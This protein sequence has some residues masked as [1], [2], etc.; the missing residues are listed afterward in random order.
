MPGAC[1]CASAV[2]PPQAMASG[3]LQESLS[4]SGEVAA[5]GGDAAAVAVAAAAA[6]MAAGPA[7]V[8]LEQLMGGG[9]LRWLLGCGD[10]AASLM[11]LESRSDL[12]PGEVM[13]L[14]HG[15]LFCCRPL[16]CCGRLQ[17]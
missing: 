4:A 6:A 7:A 14:L 2:Q 1:C 8:P 12:V 15:E 9:S 16:C 13:Q 5:A 10:A 11:V 3:S 17:G